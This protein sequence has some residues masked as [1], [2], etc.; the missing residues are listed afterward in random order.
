MLGGK[1]NAV[2]S[3]LL[4]VILPT[5]NGFKSPPWEG[6]VLCCSDKEM[7]KRSIEGD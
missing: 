4:W 1:V 6:S 7:V 5:W 2:P 3:Y